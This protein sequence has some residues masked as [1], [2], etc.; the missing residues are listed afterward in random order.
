MRKTAVLLSGGVDSLVTARILKDQGHTIFGIHFYTGYEGSDS[1]RPT[2]AGSPFATS[3]TE[4]RKTA[5]SVA[6]R[7][8]DQ[9]D[10]PI[11]V[12]DAREVFQSVVVN[13]FVRTYQ[14]GRTPNPCTVCNPGIKF[15]ACLSLAVKQGASH[16]ATGHY[17][18][19]EQD[20][21]GT[22]HLFRG[23]D[24][25][26]DQSYFLARLNQQMLSRALFPLG[27]YNKTE[28]IALSDKMG[29]KP[30]APKESQ[31]ICFIKGCSYGDFLARQPGFNS[32]K[33]PVEDMNGCV[34][35][36]HRGLHHYTIG[37]RRGI[38]IPASRPYYVIRMDA[39]QNRLVVGFKQATFS[40]ACHVE[41]IQWI[42]EPTSRPIHV[43]TRIR[44][45][46]KAATS[47]LT[48]VG[49]N[50]A[51]ICFDVPQSAITPG[52]AAVFYDN[53]EV[54]GGGWIVAGQSSDSC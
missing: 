44:Y 36:E 1:A 17:A 8:S 49:G 27:E 18:R 28:T 13:Y 6:S 43:L 12:F 20:S 45:R 31:D 7:L 9:L 37:Q 26:K 30:V 2:E 23:K 35:G 22:F 25:K 5:G 24:D 53:T 54:L 40:T 46:H 11:K 29:L 52:Q 14:E 39:Q 4:P 47:Q 42:H 50:T 51:R 41:N 34:I 15:G 3:G 19:V 10:I 38:D 32:Q 48:P 21:N 33:G 16:L